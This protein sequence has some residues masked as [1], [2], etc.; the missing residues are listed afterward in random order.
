VYQTSTRPTLDFFIDRDGTLMTQTGVPL[1]PFELHM[2]LEIWLPFFLI[3][4]GLLAV[5]AVSLYTNTVDISN[6]LFAF[7]AIVA[8]SF[9]IQQA[10][11]SV[12]SDFLRETRLVTLF[13]AVPWVALVGVVL[14]HL[15][16]RLTSPTPFSKALAVI[17]TPFYAF[18]ILGAVFGIFIYVF[19]NAPITF[20]MTPWYNLFLTVSAGIGVLWSLA[21]LTWAWRRGATRRV[22]ARSSLIFL[23]LVIIPI[24]LVPYGLVMFT[25]ASVFPF[26]QDLPYLG[27]G[28]IAFISYGIL[29][30][31]VYAVKARILTGLL[32]LSFCILVA[33]LVDLLVGNRAAF[34]PILLGTLATGL[35]L[36]SRVEP[37]AAIDR[38][39]R[40][41]RLDYQAVARFSQNVAGLTDIPCLVRSAAAA[42]QQ[43][44]TVEQ[45]EF[46]LHGSQDS[47]WLYFNGGEVQPLEQNFSA[48][49]MN[50]WLQSQTDNPF[51]VKPPAAPP[52]ALAS[53][54]FAG[55]DLWVPLSDRE[56]AIGLLRLGP[57]WTGVT[58]SQ[59][60]LRL[61]SIMARQLFLSLSNTYQ[62]ER[63]QTMQQRIL[64]AE[65]NERVKIARELH[66]TLLQFLLV[67]NYGLD[68][69]K[70]RPAHLSQ[71]IERW[72]DRISAEARQLR[73]LVSYLRSPEILVQRG[74]VASL[75]TWF[76]QTRG[77]TQMPLWVDLDSQA[78]A[79][80]PL[81]AQIALYRVF[82]E[83]V[84]NAI[85]H[86]QAHSIHA[87]L[88]QA[89]KFVRFE[90]VDDG[91]GFV[92]SE[93]M[94]TDGRYHSLRDMLIYIESAG[95][96][97]EIHTAP[98][99]GTAVRGYFSITQ[100]A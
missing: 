6:L 77:E 81:E 10:Y 52:G 44:L 8:G 59:D 83:A 94:Q 9:S 31:Q 71:E 49:S 1:V 37:F 89:E 2:L 78:G 80:L 51:P 92:L 35:A 12:F 60:D 43:E 69:L 17:R 54:P 47:P 53:R 100:P 4:A 61:V 25:S 20:S 84:H 88:F 32:L 99:A 33:Y 3:G 67:L 11:I 45:V 23:S 48:T 87:R 97:L 96:Q 58:W 95:G 91:V 15:T 21:T 28:V 36:E 40:R 24:L 74:L 5:G 19:N 46:W 56:H 64:Q 50:A 75:Q 66:D 18:S 76:D 26:L 55:L 14:M 7:I 22:R 62:V 29:R 90:I 42:F 82:R 39:L 27:L 16:D 70:D 38:L 65:E 57:R 63:L 68:G 41:E 72:Q 93:Y 30:F 86:A 79:L 34:L 85:K 73:D 98:G 13:M